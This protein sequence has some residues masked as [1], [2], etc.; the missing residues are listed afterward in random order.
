MQMIL[1]KKKVFIFSPSGILAWIEAPLREQGFEVYRHVDSSFECAKADLFKK[2]EKSLVDFSNSLKGDERGFVH[3]GS[4]CWGERPD[5]GCLC[6]SLGLISISPPV[7]TLSFFIDQ[8]YFLDQ[9]DQLRIPHLVD[10]FN[11][12]RSVREIER[13]YD[14][15]VDDGRSSFLLRPMKAGSPSR[16]V[17]ITNKQEIQKKVPH[18][19]ETLAHYDQET[20]IFAERSLG[21]GARYVTLP[22]VRFQNGFF[23]TFPVIDSSL[24]SGSHKVIYFCPASNS[25]LSRS[26]YDLIV[27]WTRSLADACRY[28]GVGAL[29]YWIDGE[30][31]YLSRGLARLNQSFPLWERVARTR[32]VSWQL[33]ALGDLAPPQKDSSLSSHGIL[34]RILSQDSNTHLPQPGV[35]QELSLSSGSIFHYQEGDTV[36]HQDSGELGMVLSVAQ[37]R[38]D[39]LKI[40][41]K[42]LNQIWIAGSLQTNE[43]FLSDVLSHPWIKEDI[44]HWHFIDEEFFPSSCPYPR[45][46]FSEVCRFGVSHQYRS[47]LLSWLEG[48]VRVGSSI[49]GWIQWGEHLKA[50]VCAYRLSEEN[51]WM[52]RMGRYFKK[53]KLSPHGKQPKIK[54]LSNGIIHSLYFS[55]GAYVPAHET[56]VMVE[57]C[58]SLIPHALSVPARLIEWKVQCRKEV[59]LGQD[60]ALL[61]LL[62]ATEE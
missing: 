32:A 12:M 11:P 1:S 41:L 29:E 8:L 5:I 62:E 48:P 50:R 6:E 21:A 44:F 60:L 54:A 28:V 52:V 35:I 38:V 31:A 49:S 39:S 15:W 55:Q 18:F 36:S 26:T 45:S 9:A 51:E 27:S 34:L 4:T 37:S 58:G 10:D 13:Y 33:A 22:F 17:L 59:S 2:I 16:A 61:E 24:K 40:I 3:F 14:L 19:L 57:A 53:V 20:F 30:D 25:S 56:V 47:S 46:L 42:E 7:S 43:F 23:D